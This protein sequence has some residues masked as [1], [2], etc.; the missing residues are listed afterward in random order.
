MH[1]VVQ[2]RHVC[3]SQL[4]SQQCVAAAAAAWL[5]YTPWASILQQ[6]QQQQQQQQE[7]QTTTAA[8]GGR[9]SS[10]NNKTPNHM[11]GALLGGIDAEH[12]KKHN[13]QVQGAIACHWALAL[14]A[15]AG[16]KVTCAILSPCQPSCSSRTGPPVCDVTG[17]THTAS[18]PMPCAQDAW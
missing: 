18:K 13:K 12:N 1:K 17:L 5:C 2:A 11:F 14:Q 10:S 3:L 7:Q 6:Q 4:L 9:V 15:T 8:A 16:V